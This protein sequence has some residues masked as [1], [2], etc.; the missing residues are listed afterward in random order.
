MRPSVSVLGRRALSL[1]GANAFEYAVQ[2]LLPVVLARCLDPEV[3]GEYR[4]PVAV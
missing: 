1:G 3:F 4:E 2:F